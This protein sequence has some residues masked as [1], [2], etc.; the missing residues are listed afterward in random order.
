MR[1]IQ[2]MQTAQRQDIYFLYSSS[3]LVGVPTALTGKGLG[4]VRVLSDILCV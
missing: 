2:V 4:V 3:V 1:T